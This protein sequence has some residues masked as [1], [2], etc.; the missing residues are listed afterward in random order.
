M[1]E[2]MLTTIDNPFNPHKQWDEWLAFD[3][4]KGYNTCSYLARKASISDSLSDVENEEIV[5]QAMKEIVQ[6][7]PIG[8]WM[9]IT[10]EMDPRPISID[11]GEGSE[12]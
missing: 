1:A 11:T 6:N 12:K 2:T 8:I 10:P 3:E 5:D 7:D 4:Q 9:L